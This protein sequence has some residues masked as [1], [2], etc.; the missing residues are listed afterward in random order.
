MNGYERVMRSLR[1]RPT[2][3]AAVV[4]ELI[5]HNL[6]LAGEVHSVFSSDPAAMCRVILAELEAAVM[7]YPYH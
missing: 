3:R 1:F 6:N 2:D 7:Q 5:Q 4:P